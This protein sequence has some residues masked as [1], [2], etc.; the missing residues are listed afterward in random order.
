M[1]PSPVKVRMGNQIK[2]NSW[3]IHIDWYQLN[4]KIFMK[5]CLQRNSGFSSSSLSPVDSSVLLNAPL[6]RQFFSEAMQSIFL[7]WWNHFRLH[8]STYADPLSPRW[9]CQFSCWDNLIHMVNN[10]GRGRWEMAY[11]L[12]IWSIWWYISCSDIFLYL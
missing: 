1:F 7:R 10:W 12:F 2:A 9:Y 5:K 11:E 8:S 3:C 6:R 4:F